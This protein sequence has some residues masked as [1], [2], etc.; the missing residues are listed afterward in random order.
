MKEG[1]IVTCYCSSCQRN[2]NHEILFTA[3]EQGDD[4]EYWWRREYYIAKCCGCDQLTFLTGTNEEGEVDYD[5][6]GKPFYPTLYKTYPNHQPIAKGLSNLWPIPNS[7]STIYKETLTALNNESYLLAAVGFRMIVEAVCL[8]N[9]IKGSNLEIKINNLCKSGLITRHD[10]DRLHSIRF[11]G[12]D[13][14]H[15]MKVSD[16]DALLLVLDIVNTLLNNLYILDN[17]CKR[18]IEGPITKFKDFES[19][20]DEALKSRQIGEVDVLKNLLPKDRRLIKE[21]IGK[22]E[23]ELQNR[24]NEGIYDKLILCPPPTQGKN[25]QYKIVKT[26]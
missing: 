15:L 17:K 7:I 21:D 6:E 12:N 9:S 23:Q 24:I 26:S 10:R 4:D 5:E 18:I 13:S 20:L 14:V 11:M 3:K 19:I 22:F 8:E 16:K 2:T 25:Q 1:K